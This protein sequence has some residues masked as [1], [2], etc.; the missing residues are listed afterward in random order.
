M[1]GLLLESTFLEGLGT[2]RA[3]LQGWPLNMTSRDLETCIVTDMG[4]GPSQFRV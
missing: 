4:L 3:A 1:N 2:A